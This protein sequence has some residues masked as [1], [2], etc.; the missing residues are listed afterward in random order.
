M[1]QEKSTNSLILAQ[2]FQDSALPSAIMGHSTKDGKTEWH[3]YGPSIWNTSDT[4]TRDHIF[5]IASMTKAITSVAALQLVERGLVSLDEP[6]YELMPEMD[7]IP[8]LTETG[9]LTKSKESIT[10]RHLLTHTSGFGY[11]F[12]S[13]RLASFE[14]TDWH[15]E[16]SPRLFEPGESWH[17]GTSIDWVGRV[18]E[19]VSGDDLETYIRKNITGP[20][21]M[22]RT[23]FNVPDSLK[24]EIVS[25]GVRDSTGFKETQR[26]PDGPVTSYSGG[27]GLYSS[28][29]DYLTFLICLLN[30]GTYDNRKILMAE[31]VEMLFQNHLPEGQNIVFDI[32]EGKFVSLAGGFPDE[33]DKHGLSWAIEDSKDEVVRSK[34]AG[35]WAGIG[36]SYYTIDKKKGVAVVYFTQFLPF[37]D[38][39]SFDFYRFYEKQVY[40][41]LD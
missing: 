30:D 22:T 40:S 35:Y 1:E 20:L 33:S 41:Q 11:S 36:N 26:I 6:L 18:V 15:Y 27:G 14:A 8:I 39:V 9:Q 7:T 21:K 23:F 12:T 3:A 34:G 10:L 5:R 16:D 24:S 19:K 13:P 28:P 31:T 4:V 29:A 32:P 38:K 37:N 17:Y 2:Y 25:W